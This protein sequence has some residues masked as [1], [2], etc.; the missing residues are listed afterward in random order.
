MYRI[1]N[2]NSGEVIGS[3]DH[4]IYIK[5]GASGDFTPTTETEAVGV[6]LNGVP[7]NLLGHTEIDGADTVVV[8]EFDGA[9]HQAVLAQAIADADGMNVEHEYRLTM[10]ELGLSD[11]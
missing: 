6:A 8:S 1:T 2:V 11:I 7:Y 5:I 9:A 10:L 3:V 4:V